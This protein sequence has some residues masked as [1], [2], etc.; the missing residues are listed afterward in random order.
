MKKVTRSLQFETE[1]DTLIFVFVGF[2]LF[3]LKTFFE[4]VFAEQKTEDMKQK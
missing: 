3:I 1:H 4:Y 2:I